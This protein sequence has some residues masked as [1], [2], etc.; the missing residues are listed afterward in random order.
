MRTY[1]V[2]PDISEKEKVIG[3]VLNMNQFFWILGGLF[4]GAMVFLIL[5]SFMGKF[6]LVPAGIICLSGIPFVL[7]KPQGLTL[8]EYL[9][10]K[11]DFKKKTKYLPNTRILNK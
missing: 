9:K 7:I 8:F 10:R 5:S 11:K 6:A 1:L 2:P 3:G 4:L